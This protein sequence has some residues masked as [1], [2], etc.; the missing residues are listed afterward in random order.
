MS[1]HDGYQPPN[2]GPMPDDRKRPGPAAPIRQ[3]A[4]VTT[5]TLHSPTVCLTPCPHAET[6]RDRFAAAAL[7]GL[8]G[9]NQPGY[10]PGHAAT[11]A[12][13]LADAMMRERARKG[14]TDA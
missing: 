6:L 8:I 5:I 4:D 12:Y 7:T 11:L 14:A 1:E 9:R 10:A 2:V 3:A 13:E